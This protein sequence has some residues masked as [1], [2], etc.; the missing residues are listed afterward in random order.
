MAFQVDT[1]FVWVSDLENSVQWYSR[2]GIDAG[3]RYGSWQNM[4]TEG[5]TQFALHQGVRPEGPATGAVAFRVT[6]LDDEIEHLRKIGI[7]PTDDKITD[8]GVARFIGFQD[9]D[10][11]DVQL[12]E[13]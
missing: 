7:E 8:T 13:R 1:V 2:F 10:G 9:P 12:L 11:N 4:S 3:H 6:S 5:R